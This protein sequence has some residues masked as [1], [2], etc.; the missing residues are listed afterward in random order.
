MIK[1]FFDQI[2]KFPILF[3]V[4]I[5]PL[6]AFSQTR[7]IMDGEFSDWDSLFPVHQDPSGD[8]NNGAID[9]GK[10]W[11]SN[12]DEYLF[13]RIELGDE[14]NLQDLNDI[15]MYLDTDNNNA[16][17]MQ[18]NTIGAELVWH[19]GGRNGQFYFGS[20]ITGIRHSNIG[21]VT[22]PT[23]SSNEFEIVLNRTAKPFQEFE[24]FT[25][26]SIKIQFANGGEHTDFLPDLGQTISFEFT[27]QTS[28]EL[29]PI[30]VEKQDDNHLRIL[31]YNVER[32]GLFAISKNV[33]YSRILGAIEPE[34]IGCQEIY[35]NTAAQTAQLIGTILPLPTGQNWHAAKIDP[36]IIAV[37]QYPIKSSYSIQNNGAFIIDLRPKHNSDLLFIVAHPPCCDNNQGRQFEIDS[38][39][40]FIRDAKTPGGRLDIAPNT[41]III[42]GDMNLVGFAKQLKTLLTGDILFT[43]QFGAA[44]APDWDES[45]LSKLFPMQVESPFV[46]TWWDANSSFSPGKLDY[47]VFTDSVLEPENGFVSFTPAL[48]SNSLSSYGLVFDDTIEAS[49][50][51][52]VVGDF[53]LKITTDVKDENDFQ[54][55]NNFKLEQN[56]PNP[57]FSS[58]TILITLDKKAKVDLSIYNM[59]GQL[60]RKLITGELTKGPYEFNWN[61]T[62]SSSK[63]VGN[64]RYFY[65]LTV[66]GKK[67]Q[68][69]MILMR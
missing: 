42:V 13:I 62:D 14:I 20:N 18:I 39:M 33:A 37:S 6:A 19:F 59:Q 15:H 46:F 57:V 28:P 53:S 52:P 54:V 8:M 68:N 25:Q 51:L 31:S 2:N 10:I 36:D 1:K 4:L 49:D 27:S 29:P 45:D 26:E 58:T 50:H 16:T 34:I 12:D 22:A 63:P 67:V 69:Q 17:G 47:I 65:R 9:F 21:I 5:F 60:I 41:P 48:S 23:V 11:M 24:L 3:L 43:G 55:P 40:A 61:G 66:D 32:D 64:G 38:I 35:S 56:Y 44:F 7:I 30:Y